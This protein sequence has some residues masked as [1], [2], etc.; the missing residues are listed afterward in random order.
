MHCLRLFFLLAATLAFSDSCRC[1]TISPNPTGVFGAG[2]SIRASAFQSDGKLVVVGQ[3][4]AIN[5]VPRVNIARLNA[6]G[7]VDLSWNPGATGGIPYDTYVSAV[8]VHGNDVYIGGTFSFAGSEPRNALAAID[9]TTGLATPWDPNPQSTNYIQ[10]GVIAVS[11]DG[12]RVYVGGNFTSIGG[13][14][15][16]SFAAIAATDGS[17]ISSWDPR[18]D[19]LVEALAISGDTL[20]V[21]GDFLNIGGQPRNHLAAISASTGAVSAWAPNPDSAV[22]AMTLAGNTLYAGGLFQSVG[23]HAHPY[24][25]AIDTTTGMADAWNPS[26]T[27]TVH[28]IAVAGNTVYLGGGSQLR[29]SVDRDR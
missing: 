28:A 9:A 12:S 7:S 27:L 14:S 26:V 13:A 4:V 16:S 8:A 25:A 5:G 22:T 18:P 15:R 20:Y 29:I 11:D 19:R 2:G 17:A 3:F 23:G 1:Q 10:I 21:G 24:V 6:D